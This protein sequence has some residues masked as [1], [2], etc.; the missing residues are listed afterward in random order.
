MIKWTKASQLTKYPKYK[1]D[2]NH[3]GRSSENKIVKKILI[4][5]EIGKQFYFDI[6]NSNRV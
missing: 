1:D 3:E 6:S 4:D 5:Y 2:N